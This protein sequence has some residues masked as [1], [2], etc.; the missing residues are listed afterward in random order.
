VHLACDG[1]LYSVTFGELYCYGGSFYPFRDHRRRP[2]YLPDVQAMGQ[3]ETDLAVAAQVAG[4][5]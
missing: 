3:F 5:G 2:D 4:T 1:H